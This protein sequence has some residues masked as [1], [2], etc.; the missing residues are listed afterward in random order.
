[1][2]ESEFVPSGEES[3]LSST[4]VNSDSSFNPPAEIDIWGEHSHYLDAGGE[5]YFSDLAIWQESLISF[6][7]S[8]IWEDMPNYFQSDLDKCSE[9]HNESFQGEAGNVNE[10]ADTQSIY[11]DDIVDGY[12]ADSND[13]E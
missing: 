9:E 10:T 1:M 2:S 8:V 4:E 13:C 3:E 11:S 6:Q 12:E 7:E 5:H